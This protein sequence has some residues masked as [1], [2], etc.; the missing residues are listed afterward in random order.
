MGRGLDTQKRKPRNAALYQDLKR[1]GGIYLMVI[2]V[3][4]FY[5]YFHYKPMY[6]MLIAFQDFNIRK[7]MSGSEWIGLENFGRLFSD[8]YFKR[9]IIN[10]FSNQYSKHC[11]RLSCTDNSCAA[12]E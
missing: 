12:Y 3:I 8:V 7:G 9:N 5:L 6:G 1:N 4:L 2:P 11:F 10:T